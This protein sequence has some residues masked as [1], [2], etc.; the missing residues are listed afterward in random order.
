MVWFEKKSWCRFATIGL[1]L[2]ALACLLGGC[3]TTSN[4]D[5]SFPTGFWQGTIT[6]PQGTVWEVHALFAPDGNYELAFD[7]GSR[8]IA[9][10]LYRIE[11]DLGDGS[12][13]MSGVPIRPG[14]SFIFGPDATTLKGRFV[15]EYA[16]RWDV[17]LQ[18]NQDTGN[19]GVLADA[20]RGWNLPEGDPLFPDI[21]LDQPGVM[22]NGDGVGCT[23]AG[24]ITQPASW[25]GWN[26]FP[27][28]LTVDN[29][30]IA[31]NYKG[32]ASLI[33]DDAGD[34]LWV[35]LTYYINDVPSTANAYFVSGE[36]SAWINRPPVADAGENLTR[37]ALL[38]RSRI[39]LDGTRSSDP[40][41]NDPNYD[42]LNYGW[43][44][45]TPTGQN[46]VLTDATTPSPSFVP[47][48]AGD[49]T[50]TLT[51]NDGELSSA[52]QSM[53]VTV[54]QA[55][56]RFIDNQNG[57]VVDALQQRVWLKKAHC[58]VSASGAVQFGV[59][60]SWIED[61]FPAF[62]GECDLRDG[63]VIGDWKMPTATE[64]SG[65][66]MTP[67]GVTTSPGAEVHI[68]NAAETGWWSG[69]ADEFVINKL[70]PGGLW[71]QFWADG[72]VFDLRA[73]AAMTAPAPGAYGW[74]MR[75][76]RTDGT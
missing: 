18:L 52:P 75:L 39:V 72:G 17:T 51:V 25:E 1:L 29:C 55:P 12:A 60:K 31:G 33:R 45:T 8:K 64:F 63:S 56:A 23:Y 69:A 74:P 62:E 54:N 28:S 37:P 22:T 71:Y 43:T 10:K 13:F 32:L 46:L 34:R 4:V 5:E 7:D 50:F 49:Y 30:Q 76:L 15:F 3:Q 9:G 21:R 65:L 27:L 16:G 26:I 24:E 68:S 40:N 47:D 67:P 42:P 35:A 58:L 61:R 57:T 73:G 70:L 20:Q 19:P 53:T 2:T 44:G 66:L 41:D 11:Q 6:D 59:Y 14:D 38:G 36:W 48:M